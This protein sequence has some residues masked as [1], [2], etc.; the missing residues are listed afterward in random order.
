[1]VYSGHT[2]VTCLFALALYDLMRKLTLLMPKGRGQVVR[3]LMAF[4]LTSLVL[5]EVVLIILNNFHYTIDVVLAI[6]LT[7][8]FY[9]NAGVV[10]P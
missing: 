3:A 4:F 1:M 10:T 9:T 2:F 6:L 5:V 7:F 8:L